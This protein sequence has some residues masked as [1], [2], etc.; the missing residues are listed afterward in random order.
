MWCCN[1]GSDDDSACGA[2]MTEVMTT[3]RAWCCNDGG[4][5]D[6][7]CGAAM[8]VAMTT[9]PVVLPLLQRKERVCM[10]LQ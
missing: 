7:T 3:V 10:V 5:D 9:V 4:N 6:S 2:A 8:T 1:D